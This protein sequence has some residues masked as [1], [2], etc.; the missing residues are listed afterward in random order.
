MMILCQEQ[1]TEMRIHEHADNTV[2][3]DLPPEPGMTEELETVITM[4]RQRVD[5]DVAIDFTNIGIVTSSSLSRLLQLRKMMHDNGRSLVLCNVAP[6]TRGIFSTIG[7]D[8][9]FEFCDRTQVAAVRQEK[10]V[11]D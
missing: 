1:V 2:I 11:A 10:S 9:L 3:I 4:V 7:F 8:E 6:I 5:R